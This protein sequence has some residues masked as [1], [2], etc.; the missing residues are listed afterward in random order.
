MLDF[1]VAKV[2]K[3]DVARYY[4]REMESRERNQAEAYLVPNDITSLEHVIP[5]KPS[6]DW[7]N[8]SSED[9]EAFVSRIGNLALLMPGTN[10]KLSSKGFEEKKK[11]YATT[12]LILTSMIANYPTWTTEEIEDR[13]KKPANIAIKTWPI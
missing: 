4:L 6:Q 3:V 5:Q 7:K 9:Q 13:Q 11:T 12:D 2:T 8:I 1:S 10:S